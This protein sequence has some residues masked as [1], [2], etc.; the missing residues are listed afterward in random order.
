MAAA[1]D[2]DTYNSSGSIFSSDLLSEELM[3]A[4]DPF[5]KSASSNPSISASCFSNYYPFGSSLSSICSES[6]LYPDFGS[7]PSKAQ[8]FSQGFSSFN[9]MGDLHHLSPSQFLQIQ[10]QFQFQQQQLLH[11][12]NSFTRFLGPKS[13]PMKKAVILPKAAKLYRGVRQRHWGKWVAEIRLPRNRS[14]LWLGTFDTAEEAALAYDKAAYKLRGELARLNFPDLRHQL[15]QEFS[16]FKPLHSSVDAKLQA[17]C[18]NLANSPK[19]GKNSGKT[20]SA[21]DPKTVT[22]RQ[23]GDEKTKSFSNDPL[24]EGFGYTVSDD[25]IPAEASSSSLSPLDKGSASPESDIT[26]L[27]ISEPSF[28][29]FDN[30]M[31]QKHPSVEIDWAAI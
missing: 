30:F 2:T 16:G 10:A 18:E 22:L 27:D 7:I 29:D 31:L 28:D 17:I 4:L 3:Q 23:T 1:I 9:E 19:Q 24:N 21:S 5:M 20:R 12:R 25:S 26:F 14:R 13:V 15:C 6:N 8:M 11:Q